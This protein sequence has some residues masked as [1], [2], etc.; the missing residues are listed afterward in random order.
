MSSTSDIISFDLSHQSPEV[1]DVTRFFPIS[2]LH[3]IR[4]TKPLFETIRPGTGKIYDFSVSRKLSVKRFR[5]LAM[6][7]LARSDLF[8]ISKLESVLLDEKPRLPTL[9]LCPPLRIPYGSVDI[10]TLQS[11]P[12]PKKYPD[13]Y[14]R[15]LPISLHTRRTWNATGRYLK[16]NRKM[17][18]GSL[19]F[20]LLLSVPT[21]VYV[22]TLVE[23]SY[24]ELSSLKSAPDLA[25]IQSHIHRARAGFERANILFFPYRILP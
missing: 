17:I 7:D 5:T 4:S 2:E 10:R 3:A 1:L 6:L 13:L 22:R 12:S 16:K 25:S 19:L 8:E 9:D 18:L 23:S 11:I 21:L 20:F 24:A 15:S 14:R